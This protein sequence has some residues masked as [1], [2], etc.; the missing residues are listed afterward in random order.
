M[1]KYITF[2]LIVTGVPAVVAVLFPGLVVLGMYMLV[3]PGLILSFTPTAFLW[4]GV[5]AAFWVTVKTPLGDTVVAALAAGLLTGALLFAVTQ[6]FRVAG[7]AL[8]RETLLPNVD[9]PGRIAMTSDVRIDVP[10]PRWDN[11][12]K[13]GKGQQRGFACDNLCL[14]LLFT[15]GVKSVTINRSRGATHADPGKGGQEFDP[16]ARTY[17]LTPRGECADGG[18]RTDLEGRSGLFRGTVEEGKALAASWQWRLANAVCLQ[19]SGAIGRHD[20]LIRHRRDRAAARGKQ[21]WSLG[22][23]V[24]HREEIEVQ[25]S[26]GAVLLRRL[27]FSVFMPSGLLAI[28]FTGGPESMRAGWSGEVLTNKPNLEVEGLL[29]LLETHTNT[30]GR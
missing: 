21:N 19:R 4:G 17:W 20:I 29:E 2:Y 3:I 22:A 30:V 8:Y 5:F 10:L 6:P 28:G 9:P 12:N 27:K 23:R 26:S 11:V 14:A 16:E 15:P 13:R 1:Q 7:N 25:D 18:L 24:S